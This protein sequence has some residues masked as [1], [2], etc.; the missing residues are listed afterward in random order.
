MSALALVR[1]VNTNTPNHFAGGVIARLIL[2]RGTRRLA[3]GALAYFTRDS[4]LYAKS[5]LV[6]NYGDLSFFFRVVRD[7]DLLRL[8]DDAPRFVAGDNASMTEA[9]EQ[10]F[11]TSGEVVWIEAA[12]S[13]SDKADASAWKAFCFSLCCAAQCWRLVTFKLGTL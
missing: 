2:P 10:I 12:Y 13:V 5:V 8:E 9:V 4:T 6:V 7:F 3:D 1:S 11:A